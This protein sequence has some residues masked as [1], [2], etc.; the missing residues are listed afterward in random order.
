MNSFTSS[1]AVSLCAA[2]TFTLVAA[3][4]PEPNFRATQ[5]DGDIKIGYG[6]ALSDVDGDS[7][8]DVILVDKDEVAWYQNPSWKKHVIAKN[9]TE[10]D[11]VCIAVRLLPLTTAHGNL[12]FSCGDGPLGATGLRRRDARNRHA[13]PALVWYDVTRCRVDVSRALLEG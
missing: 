12:F 11:H 10:K 9:L 8:I 3:E 2:T 5:I 7:K 1:L 13:V 4:P 6:L